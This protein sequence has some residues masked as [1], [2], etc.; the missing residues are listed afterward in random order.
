ML[1]LLKKE[2]KEITNKL[3]SL[4]TNNVNFDSVI[5]F[6]LRVIPNRPKT[7]RTPGDVQY[8]KL[9]VKGKGNLQIF[10]SCHLMNH[11]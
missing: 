4:L 1:L 3:S 5:E 6:I 9:F 2:K 11:P 7:E 8:A 10:I